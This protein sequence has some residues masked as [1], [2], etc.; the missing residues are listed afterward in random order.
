[1][2]D[3]LSTDTLDRLVPTFDD[4]PG[5]WPDAL[6]RGGRSRRPTVRRALVAAVAA[7]VL[8]VFAAS[9]FGQDVLSG[10]LDQLGTWVGAAPGN[11]ASEEDQ[12]AF[13]AANA[14]SYARFPSGTRVGSLVRASLQGKDYTLL[15]FRDGGSLC[16]RLTGDSAGE[17]RVPA[18]CAPQRE[19][20]DLRQ[21]AALLSS[22]AQVGEGTAIYGVAADSVRSV[23]LEFSSGEKQEAKVANNAFL[24]LSP[25]NLRL[26]EAAPVR[27]L[28]EEANG[29]ETAIPVV[30][31]VFRGGSRPDA[32][33]LPGPSVV[34]HKIQSPHVSW[35]EQGEARGEPY[36]WP[37]SSLAELVNSRVFQPDPTSSFRLGVAYGFGS[38]GAERV[39]WYCFA[40]LWPLVKGTTAWGCGRAGMPE[41]DITLESAGWSDQFSLY[42]GLAA[43]GVASLELFFPNGSSEDVPIVSNV[44]A[45]QIPTFVYTKLVAY[46][47]EHRVVGIHV[48]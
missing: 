2:S 41:G 14:S 37:G 1:V 36:D 10:T 42:A 33:E 43:D 39:S 22:T 32:S 13:D 35:L 20:V 7:A 47:A 24:Y 30:P 38:D 45:V 28:V 25:E 40:W 27:A 6:R 48:L 3:L 34:D 11:Q 26:P 46:D 16:L 4:V 31:Q 21:P 19:L 8:G 17:G 5:D 18:D 9:S 15:G 44:Y 23:T 12:A 29:D